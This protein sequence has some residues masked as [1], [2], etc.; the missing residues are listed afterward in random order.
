MWGRAWYLVF[1]A[2]V[3]M[4][5]FRLEPALHAD[6]IMLAA[7]FLAD[8][9]SYLVDLYGNPAREGLVREF[10]RHR[11]TPRGI[12]AK[13]LCEVHCPAARMVTP[14]MAL[15]RPLRETF[16]ASVMSIW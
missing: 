9:G 2:W 1:A 8:A 12:V 5:G 4:P 14:V 15:L 10:Q 3:W 16:S 13:P 6:W 11:P 7:C